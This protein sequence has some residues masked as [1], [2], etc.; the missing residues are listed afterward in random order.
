MACE[1]LTL[2]AGC[3]QSGFVATGV[4]QH[5]L[6]AHHQLGQEGAQVKTPIRLAEAGEY[7]FWQ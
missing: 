2:L 6:D 7:K 4:L 1:G 5:N 3:L